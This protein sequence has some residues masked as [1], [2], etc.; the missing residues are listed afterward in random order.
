V[1]FSRAKIAIY[2][3]LVFL[4]GGVLGVFGT[5]LY[6]A[7]S[8]LSARPP[9]R[10]PEEFRKKVLAELQSRLKLNAEQVV[11]L[12][13]IMDETEAKVDE[14]RKQ[15]HPAYIKIHEEQNQKIHN[16]LTADQ[17]V[18]FDKMRKEREDREKQNPGGR[19]PGPGGI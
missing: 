7:T 14:T 11:Q 5:R 4:C 3:A 15:M 6:L 17:Q 16:M 18:E 1:K 13:G 8:V 9:R 2:L 10:N 12:N 19:G